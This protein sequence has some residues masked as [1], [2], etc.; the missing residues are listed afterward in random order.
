MRGWA[1]LA[2]SR[3]AG[4]AASAR[5]ACAGLGLR[6][7]TQVLRRQRHTAVQSR[8]D[9]AARRENLRGAFSVDERHPSL[10]QPPWQ[11]VALV[12]DVLTTGS[13]LA[14]ATRALR[15]IGVRKI[16]WWTAASTTLSAR[17][18]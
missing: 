1:A 7:T 10:P 5:F 3:A 8:L 6:L 9:A 13:T 12:D 15:M 4:P 14:A 18:R 2:R 17:E 16:E 11:H